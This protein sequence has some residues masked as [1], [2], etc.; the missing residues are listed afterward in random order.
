[1]SARKGLNLTVAPKKVQESCVIFR[2]RKGVSGIHDCHTF[3][4]ILTTKTP[5]LRLTFPK[6]PL[7][8]AHKSVARACRT[9][10]HEKA[11]FRQ[12]EARER[13]EAVAG[14]QPELFRMLQPRKAEARK[15]NV[16]DVAL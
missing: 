14:T 3:H 13:L 16:R 5:R 9:S 12:R 4:H 6:T 10:V 8:N 7:K 1:M 11:I 2:P 15:S